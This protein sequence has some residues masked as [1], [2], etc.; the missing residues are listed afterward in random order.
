MTNK[1][2]LIL[3]DLHCGHKA[4]LTDP[5]RVPEAAYPNVAALAR[6][7]WCEYA[8]LPER[9]GPIHA[10]VVNG[11]A[12]DGKGGKSGGTELLTADRAVQVDM[13]EECLQIWKPTA[14]FHF[15]YG[16]PYHTGE[17]ED[18]E[19]VL[20]KRMSAPIHSHLWLDV[21]GYI[22]D[23]KHKCGGSAIPHGRA[24]AA[25]R[26]ALWSMLW[27]D[28]D[29]QPKSNAIV[30]SH[31]HFALAV[32]TPRQ[33]IFRTPAL[34]AADTKYGARQCSGLVDWGVMWLDI[35]SL[36][37]LANWGWYIVACESENAKAVKI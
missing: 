23:C 29:R 18:W 27:A 3:A 5:S 31:C 10:V 15:T 13:A 22:I 4:G 17:A 28:A 20:A 35:N 19:G 6:E 37:K 30:R 25:M 26:E 14:G 9:L 16:T 33:Q 36:G 2:I 11:D 34:Q 12:I 32:K 24:T 8:S 21:D 1:R 7:T